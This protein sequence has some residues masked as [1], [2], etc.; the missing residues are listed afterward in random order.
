VKALRRGTSK[1]ARP[2][3]RKRKD[4]SGEIAVWR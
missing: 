4:S 2:R 1:G 3:D